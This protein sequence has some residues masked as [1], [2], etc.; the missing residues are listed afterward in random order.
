MLPKSNN[1]VF[2]FKNDDYIGGLYIDGNINNLNSI[3]IFYDDIEIINYNKV[4]MNDMIY[5]DSELFEKNNCSV[6]ITLGFNEQIVFNQ[7]IKIHFVI[8]NKL[9]Y[10]DGLIHKILNSLCNNDHIE[11][12][13]NSLLNKL[14]LTNEMVN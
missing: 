14:I 3:N 6:K 13:E 7:H 9:L 10:K 1:V 12:V 4:L 8:K 5:I 11:Y 2:E